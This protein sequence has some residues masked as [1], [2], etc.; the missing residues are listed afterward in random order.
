MPI[1]NQELIQRTKDLHG[2]LYHR[3]NS[4]QV[5]I[6]RLVLE[7]KEL[8]GENIRLKRQSFTDD[9]ISQMRKTFEHALEYLK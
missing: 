8:K 6:N 4:L 2:E 9:E 1:Y 5:Q 7:N 3:I